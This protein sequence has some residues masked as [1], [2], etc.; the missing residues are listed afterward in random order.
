M[1]EL[2]IGQLWMDVE[3][4]Q[5]FEIVRIFDNAIVCWFGENVGDCSSIDKGY[6]GN[7]LEYIGDL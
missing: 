6:F 1:T 2:Q 7:N 5:I 3:D 4:N